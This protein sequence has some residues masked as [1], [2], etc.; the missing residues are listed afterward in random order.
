MKYLPL[1]NYLTSQ[2]PILEPIYGHGIET[3]ESSLP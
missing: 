3:D 1:N 2:V